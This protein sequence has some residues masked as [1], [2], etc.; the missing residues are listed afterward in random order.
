MAGSPYR[1]SGFRIPARALFERHPGGI[2]FHTVV[3]HEG[4]AVD[5]TFD[6]VNPAFEKLTGL[7]ACH[8]VGKT[9]R[10]VFRAPDPVTLHRVSE[11]AARGTQDT[12][13][14]WSQVLDRHLRVTVLG[15]APGRFMSTFEPERTVEGSSEAAAGDYR[16]FFD[17]PNAVKLII[18]PDSHRI[19]DADPSAEAFYGWTRDEL[20]AM[21][22]D[23]INLLDTERLA[24][25]VREAG[26]EGTKHYFFQHRTRDGGV[27][28]VEVFTTSGPWG[29]GRAN[30]AIVHDITQR[31]QLERT[32]LQDE[33]LKTVGELTA[34]L[35]HE[36]GNLLGILFG[37]IQL[38]ELQIPEGDSKQRVKAQIDGQLARARRLIESVKR[39]SRDQGLERTQCRLVP[40]LEDLLEVEGPA[41]RRARIAVEFSPCEGDLVEVD[42]VLVQQVFLNLFK[43][44]LE[45]LESTEGPRIRIGVVVDDRDV[46]VRFAN[47]GPLIGPEDRSRLFTRFFTTKARPGAEGTGLGLSFSQNVIASHGG[48]LTLEEDRE[49][50]F[51][52]R[53]PRSSPR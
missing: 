11:V 40:L 22:I 15:N 5:Y 38:L 27:R 34:S 20:R 43:N 25:V 26:S 29:E 49:T 7:E 52:V 12:V 14:F 17:L 10:E 8:I 19:L 9:A 46:V 42:S 4:R 2:G 37:Q 13:A 51:Q 47:N 30:Y 1:P 16:T 36:F 31:R 45:A 35:Y 33:R 3:Y 18:D 6:A 44:A 41:C 23:D 24:S 50:T 39:F 32:S 21:R 28:D 48:S 53:L